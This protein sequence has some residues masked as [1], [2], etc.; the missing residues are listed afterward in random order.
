ML[1]ARPRW[2]V[3]TGDGASVRSALNRTVIQ[4]VNRGGAA[5]A[6]DVIMIHRTGDVER[7]AESQSLLRR[8]LPPDLRADI[9]GGGQSWKYASV[10]DDRN[11]PQPTLLIG[12][13]M[14]SDATG[15]SRSSS[16]TSSH[17]LRRRRALSLIRSTV[18]ISG[19]ALTLFVVG[20]GVLV[21]RLV[22]DPVRRAAGT[23]SGWRRASWSSGMTVRGGR[24]RPAGDQFQRDGRQPATADHPAG[25]LSQLQQRS[26]R[27]LARAAD[28]VTTV[29]MAADVLHDARGI[30]A[31]RGPLGRLLR[32]ELDRFEGLL[33]DL[34]GRSAVRRRRRR[35]RLRARRPR[36]AGRPGGGRHVGALRAARPPSWW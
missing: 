8:A 16:T 2:P 17:S 24:P 23:P 28:A 34:L 27:R 1:Y 5:G 21:T 19:V 22:V 9:A 33:T 36:C 32:A 13:A 11:E 20:I 18:I 29:Q 35:P 30:P 15:S 12:L 6:F 14:P 31:A 3:T 26:P 25:G 7:V 4:L 10:P